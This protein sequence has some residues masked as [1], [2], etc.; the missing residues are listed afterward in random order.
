M[1]VK[2]LSANPISLKMEKQGGQY[3]CNVKFENDKNAT[4]TFSNPLPF[5]VC[6][7]NAD[8]QSEYIAISSDFFKNLIADIINFYET[9]EYSFDT[10]ETLNAM[11]IRTGAIAAMDKL[12]EWITL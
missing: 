2:V 8:G 6:A 10:K 5:T 3:I 11:K 12:N 9:G 4:M 1:A 7:E